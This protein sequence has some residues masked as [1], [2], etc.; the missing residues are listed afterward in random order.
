MPGRIV[1]DRRVRSVAITACLLCAAIP[2]H[3]GVRRPQSSFGHGGIPA[4]G[5]PLFLHE[6]KHHT[7]CVQGASSPPRS[8][9]F[10]HLFIEFAFMSTTALTA[11]VWGQGRQAIALSAQ[12][13]KHVGQGEEECHICR[14][15]IPATISFVPCKHKVCFGCVENMR[16]KNIFKVGGPG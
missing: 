1:V 6:C 16:A 2:D 13:A 5:A 8:A 14:D 12:V 3:A 9:G 10:I 4:V 11:S 15:D 7:L